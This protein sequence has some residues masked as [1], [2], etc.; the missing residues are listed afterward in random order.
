M[1]TFLDAL[2]Q[3]LA[4][5]QVSSPQDASLRQLHSAVAHVVT[6]R[7][8]PKHRAVRSGKTACY[9]SAEFLLGR[10]LYSNL[11]NLGLLNDADD[12]FKELGLQLSD[13]E[14]LED[15]ALGNG[16]LGRLAACFLDSTATHAIPLDGYG[17]RYRY[18][19]FKQRFEDGFQTELPDDWQRFGDPW[20]RRNQAA[21]VPVHFAGESVWA[22]PYDTPVIGYG[23]ETVNNLRL[24]QAEAMNAFDLTPFNEGDFM[25]A[26]SESNSA[27][28][29][30]SVLY[31]NDETTEGQLLR[32]KQQYFFASASVQ[33]ILR[34]YKAAHGTDFTALPDY[35]VIQLNDTHP[36]I[37][38]PELLRLLIEEELLGFEAA[39]EVVQK[40]FAYTNHTL[41][42]EALEK[43]DAVLFATLL[44]HVYP[45]IVALNNRLRRELINKDIDAEHFDD[46]MILHGGDIHMARMAVYA[47]FSTNG[48]AP[49]H[50]QLI[51]RKLFNRWHA[52]YPTRFNNKTNGVT[53]RR[54]LALCNPQLAEFI[55]GRIGT[56]WVTDL[57]E[58]NKL[59]KHTDDKQALKQLAEIKTVNKNRLVK[60]IADTEGIALSADTIFDIQ[61]K[62]MHEY[63]RQLLNAF[64]IMDLY[65]MLKDGEIVNF[66][67]TTFIFGGKAAPGYRRAKGV[68]KYIN[69]IADFISKDPNVKDKI[70]VHFVENYNV[71]YAEKLIPAADISQQI[72][73]AGTEASGTGN[74]KFMM[75]GAVTLGTYDGANIEIVN[76]AGFENNYIFGARVEDIEKLKDDYN[77]LRIYQTQPRIKRVVDTLVD[78]TVYD[79]G[80]GLF[81]ELYHALLHGASWHQPDHYYLLLDLP[82][83]TEERIKA[84]TDYQNRAAFTEKCFNNIASAGHF[85]S[86]RTVRQYADDIWHV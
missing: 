25:A 10:L 58:L 59:K 39:F 85:S 34:D 49:L 73:T 21:K 23:G 35:Y 57:S 60:H 31:P 2:Q 69:E 86:D 30:H 48:V 46:Y 5:Q 63:K 24:W 26:F 68:I 80:T 38:I 78:G 3:Q 36:T 66:A 47:T 56:G 70:K 76:E 13:F 61:I 72:S 64:S 53:Q 27:E 84:N 83:Y 43:W 71:S 75:N 8:Q 79:D 22:V 37:A 40:T 6:E 16:G 65:F 29:I 19:L 41:M 42:D 7:V 81:E 4:A 14:E 54:W 11:L 12:A 28:A 20:S 15:A 9:F 1:N 82:A 17:L 50:S 45:Y 55:S 33:S 51:E 44:P 32:L 52:L 18:G 77:P 62:R 67:P 74:M